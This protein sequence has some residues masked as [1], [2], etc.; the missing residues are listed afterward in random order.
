MEECIEIL[1]VSLLD[2]NRRTVNGLR[3]LAGSLG[4]EFGWHY[5]LDLTWAI[6]RLG[7]A[8]GQRLMDA[9][10]GTGVLQWYLAGQGAEVVSVDRMSR[11]HL[12]VRFRLRYHVHGLRPD[13]LAPTRFTKRLRSGQTSG[14]GERLAGSILS[15]ARKNFPRRLD[16]RKGRVV[17]YNQDL[18]SLEDLPDNSL[19]AVVAISSLEH[20]DPADLPLVVAELMRLIKPGG[21][22]LAT[23]GAACDR[24]WFHG[25][26]RGW[27]YTEA[28]LRQLFSLPAQV[29]SN[30]DQ[31][32]RLFT[33]LKNCGE[34]RYNLAEFYYRSG[35]N[36]MPW[37]IW[38]PQY[39][40]VGVC[41]VKADA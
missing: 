6:A 2:K 41:K 13:D 31:H 35:E 21:A 9:G 24:D 33:E 23:L 26:S 14:F 36:G 11:S 40:P 7:P 12:P 15:Q 19:D 16:L 32:D 18:K 28:S 1:P 3:R 5:L 25:P 29:V 22:L 10:A 4:L 38:E 30:Y 17:I 27:C 39:I 34:L 8:R 20:N 37:G